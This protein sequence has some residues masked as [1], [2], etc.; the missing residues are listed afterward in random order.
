[1]RKERILFPGIEELGFVE[2]ILKIFLLIGRNTIRNKL[3][4]EIVVFFFGNKLT[5]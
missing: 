4:F 2:Y 1:M 5:Q 3:S